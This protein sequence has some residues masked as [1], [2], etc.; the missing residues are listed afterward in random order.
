MSKA[1]TTGRPWRVIATFAVP[2]LIGNVVQQLYHFVDAIVVGRVLGINSL[3][4][5]GATG[6]L[7][8]LLIGFAW[9]TTSGF[10][11]PTAQAFGAG[12]HAAVRRSVATGAILTGLITVVLSVGAPLLAEP[13]LRLLRTPEE[14]LPEATTFAVISFLGAAATMFFNFLSSVIRAIGDSRTPL[15][16]LTVS[17]VINI[18]LVVGLVGGLGT[19]VGGAALATVAS[20]AI[21]VALCML[22][23]WRRLPVLHVR[24][25]DWRVSR[26]DVSRHL[27]LGLPM[28]FQ[29]SIIAIGALA[30]QVRLNALGPEAVA[31]Y[32]TAGRVDQLAVTLLSSLGLA[33]SM[34]VAQN[35]GGGRPDRIRAGVVQGVWMAVAASV[36][37]GAVLIAFGSHLVGLF[38]GDGE[39]H[40]VELATYLLVVNGALYVVLGV[41]MVLRG[42]LQG[43]G[44]TV[45]PTVTGIV[46]LVMRVGAA[47]VLGAAY[48]YEGV[49]WGNPLAWLGAVAGLIPA[50]VRAHRRLAL[51]PI[52]PMARVEATPDPVAIG[53]PSEGSMVVDA[54]V[55]QH[56]AEPDGLD[57]ARP[58][59]R[60]RATH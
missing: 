40:V 32:T 51:E 5:V 30:V 23:V 9:G 14:L 7:L 17:C 31:A 10:A 35:L 22:Y 53:G 41:L 50:Y 34:F 52:A 42:A 39:Q 43:L 47:V 49:V 1:L 13:A 4:A 38:V 57:D 18:G 15:V 29:A 24:R 2:L 36:V 59:L 8:F 19:G 3:A 45:V 11:I 26:A 48:G 33:M 27:Q 16:F 6:S 20:Q 60:E 12:D 37:L 54:V 21:A 56:R 58:G 55:P 44:H 28:G 46:E 25:E